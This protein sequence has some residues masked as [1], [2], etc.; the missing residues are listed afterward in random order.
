MQAPL[1]VPKVE[2]ESHERRLVARDPIG[3]E[4]NAERVGRRRLEDLDFE[5][6]LQPVDAA[7]DAQASGGERNVAGGRQRGRRRHRELNEAELRHAAS[8]YWSRVRVDVR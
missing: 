2:R 7:S 1:A 3:E 8:L 5:A 6:L 4:R